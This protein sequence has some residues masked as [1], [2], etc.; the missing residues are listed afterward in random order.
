MAKRKPGK[1]DHLLPKLPKLPPQDLEYQ[2]R[3]EDVKNMLRKCSACE[4]TGHS[5]WQNDEIC[6]SCEGTG[7]RRLNGSDIGKMYAEA[8]AN[9]AEIEAVQ[10]ASNLE[11]EALSQLLVASQDSGNAD[12][13]A[14]GASE[15]SLKLV[16]GDTI[17]VQPEIY[18]DESNKA[19]FRDWCY[20]NGFTNEMELPHSK[21]VALV[22]KRLFE[23]KADPDHV[24]VY[25]RNKIVYT[26]F[27]AAAE[28]EVP[29]N[30]DDVT[31]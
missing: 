29:A 12:W 22:K 23:G 3:V 7:R 26:P 18:P 24:K 13:G 15:R 19:G 30:T 6:T 8:R 5:A 10:K 16:N 1:Y 31:F 9:A 21:L 25:V 11:L 4:G 20:A 28:S 14:Y 2:L 27:K 17:R